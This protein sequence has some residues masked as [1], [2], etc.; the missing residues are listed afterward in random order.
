VATGV[1]AEATKAKAALHEDPERTT[2]LGLARYATEFFEAA[3]A[4][5]DKLGRRAGYEV[6]APYR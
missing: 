3:L 4:A 5:D 6:I 1:K 2:P